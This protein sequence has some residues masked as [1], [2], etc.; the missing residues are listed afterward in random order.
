MTNTVFWDLDGTLID[1][2]AV[3]QRSMLAACE[4]VGLALQT[5]AEPPAGLDGDATF[6]WF[7]GIQAEL[8]PQLYQQWY[9]AT[10]QYVLAHLT[11]CQPIDWACGWVKQLAQVGVSQ[12]LVTNSDRLL[13]NAVLRQLGLS[14]CF[15][16]IVSRD[17]VQQGK[18]SAEPYLL[19]LQRSGAARQEALAI[20]DSA[21]GCKAAKLAG[22][23]V[24]AVA[25]LAEDIADFTLPT[26]MTVAQQQA[27]FVTLFNPQQ[28]DDLIPDLETSAIGRAL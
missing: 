10:I 15:A 20:E 28:P 26:K 12:W 19:A 9:Q 11:E 1:S 22:L 8:Q 3:H 21:S 17:Q 25:P 2:A 24:L 13:A 14:E 7:T 4:M 5:P 18:P 16:G 27:W 23:P 6:Y